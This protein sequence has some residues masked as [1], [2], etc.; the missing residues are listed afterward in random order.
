MA[1]VIPFDALAPMLR[2]IPSL[3]RPLLARLT[4]KMIERMDELDG[5]SDREDGDAD[6]CDAG[7]DGCGPIY[8]YGQKHWGAREEELV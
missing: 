3:P 2:V 7:D 6:S 8:R 4:E 5:D 1:T